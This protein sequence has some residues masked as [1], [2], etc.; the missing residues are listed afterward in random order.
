MP[1]YLPALE[2]TKAKKR[3]DI[4]LLNEVPLKVPGTLGLKGFRN[5]GG[6]QDYFENEILAR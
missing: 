6:L 2:G 1:R 3:P 4:E 5:T